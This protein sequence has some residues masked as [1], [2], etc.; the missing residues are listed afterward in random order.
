MFRINL[1]GDFGI[2]LSSI[3]SD[4]LA[5]FVMQRS[6][7]SALDPRQSTHRSKVVLGSPSNK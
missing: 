7:D 2:L 3:T 4:G 6:N 5:V 1:A